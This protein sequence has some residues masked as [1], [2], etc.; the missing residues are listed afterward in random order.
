[1]HGLIF[2]T[3]EKFLSETYGSSLLDTYR[4]A[5]GETATTSPLVSKVYDDAALLAGAQLASTLTR[6]PL[7][8]LLRL[9]GRYF[10]MNGL[11]SHLCSYLLTQVH[12]ARDLLLTMRAAHA[13]LRRTPDALTPPLFSYE[14][15]SSNPNEL[16]LIYDSQRQL[17]PLLFGAIEGAAGRYG[18]QVQVRESACM[19]QG[20][21]VCRFEI[22]F[23]SS[24][25]KPLVSE[26]QRARQQAKRE[27]AELLL[28]VLPSADG[29]TLPQVQALL[30]SRRVAP[31]HLR[32]SLLLEALQHLQYV[33][34]VCTSANQ[35][36][37]TL[38][39]RRYWRA[40]TDDY[41]AQ[42]HAHS[43]LLTWEDLPLQ[44]RA[45]GK[46]RVVR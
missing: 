5:L 43:T 35:P 3:W 22:R 38:A 29:V 10:I 33:G 4:A 15:L 20:Q 8:T 18:E 36:G 6:V 19:R 1:M 21:P 30:Q 9:Y 39:T 13:Q 12:G 27:L 31:A 45:T 44:D 2:V 24:G 37:D 23:L 40:P 25:D 17:C 28:G 26:Q 42:Q 32:P 11:T 46:Q 16:T 7:D 41:R 34:L 14:M